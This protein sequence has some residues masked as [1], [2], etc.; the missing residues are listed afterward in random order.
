MRRRVTRRRSERVEAAAAA[1]PGNR[2][3]HLA[4]YLTLTDLT[5]LG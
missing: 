3:W 1:E 4:D 5:G 2:R